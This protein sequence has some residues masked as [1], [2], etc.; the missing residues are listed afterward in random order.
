MLGLMSD[1]P[2]LISSLIEHADR[3]HGKTEI[4]CRLSNGNIER[5]NYNST[6]KRSKKLAKALLKKGVKK[7]DVIATMAWSHTRHYELYYGIS[8]LGAVC[9][10][11]N[12]R[13]FSEQISFIINDAKDKILFIDI[14]FLSIVESLYDQLTSL[15]SIIILCQNSEM[16]KSNIINNLLCYEDLL[17]EQ[18]SSFNWPIF[19]ERTA[20]SL[21][22]TSGTTGNPKGVLYTHRSTIIHSL[23][24]AA[25]DLFSLS[26]KEVVM[27]IAPMF[28]AN[29]WGIP[30]VA[31]MV[32]AKLVLPG[33]LLDGKNIHDL[34]VRENVSFTAA[35][36]SVWLSL[37]EYLE[38]S[39]NKLE[40]LKR[41]VVGGSAC[42]RS[43][44]EEFYYKYDVIVI[45]AWGMTETSPLGTVNV[46][47]PK[48]LNNNKKEKF[49]L[50]TKQGRPMYGIE[51]RIT[52][53]KKHI[54]PHNGES[55]GDL[56]VK[57][58]WVCSG[59]INITNSET[60][61]KD[62]WFLTG[63]VA[64][65]DEDGFMHITDRSKDVI[66][67]GGE[68][69]SSI[70]I[71]NIAVGYEKISEAAVIGVKHKKWAERPLLI[72]VKALETEVTKEEIIAY[73]NNKISKWWM[74]DDIIFIDELPHTATGKIRK[75]ELR[76]KYI[77]YLL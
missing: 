41:C 5:T 26:A 38:L 64:T 7:G 49:N 27:P 11:I 1:Q 23:A 55:F 74:P 48:H 34:I 56:W 20:S 12:P 9:H 21:C 44:M 28:H 33:R 43:M 15:E 6:H 35:V 73:M 66:K 63:D 8:G 61:S 77:N 52:D 4:V 2:L 37:F 58:P 71:E 59:Y 29:A 45:H 69:I 47:L 24:A 62:G 46:Q 22:Y 32:G 10:T 25:P 76:D 39:K 50:A 17:E 30:Y 54:L 68:W 51:L 19:D 14:E 70:E 57:G 18:D 31:T 67:S 65:I 42:P 13:L 75:K 40:P 72:I 60:H 3:Y 16:P 36:P 53:D